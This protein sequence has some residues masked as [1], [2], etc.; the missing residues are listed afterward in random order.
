M[1]VLFVEHDMDMVRDISDWVV[2]MAAGPDHRRGPAGVD[3]PEPGRH[4]RLPRRAPRR[5]ADRRGGGPR[6]S[7]RPSGDRPRG[8]RRGRDHQLRRAA[9]RG[10]SDERPAVRGRRDRRGRH[11]S[12]R[13]SPPASSRRREGGDPRGARAPRR[14]RP[15]PGRRPRRR[16]PARGQHPQRLRPLPAGRRARRHHRP[17]RR[18]QVDAAQ[19]DVR[20]GQGPLGHGRRCAARTSPAARR[21]SWSPWA[22]AS[23]RRPTTCSP[24]SPSRRTCRWAS[25]CG[26]R[27]SSERFDFVVDLFPLL[28]ERR[29]AQGRLAVGRRA[30]DGRH[31][32]GA[33]D[34]PV[35]AAARRAVG[36]PLPG[37]AGRG[38]HPLPADQRDRRL[39]H[40]GRAERPP[41]P[42]DLRPRLR[43]RP[44]PQRLH[45][46]RP[47]SC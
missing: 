5:A 40:H 8:A 35:G 14:G 29:K 41:L 17:Q 36:R 27:R 13:A 12:R 9:P 19:G 24:P 47:A 45:R 31:G 46:H 38:V 33:D 30:A 43:A 6:C 28:G 44:G 20:P 15:G 21:T 42:A 16:L 39:D 2:V 34:G 1:T 4:R 3:Q 26:P 11:P 7:P 10:P 32:P 23:C 37:A 18:R 22:S 25:T